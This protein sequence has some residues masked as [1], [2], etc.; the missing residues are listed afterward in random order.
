MKDKKITYLIV[1]FI[2]L[3]LASIYYMH[4]YLEFSNY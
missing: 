2:L 1:V 3:A 4:N